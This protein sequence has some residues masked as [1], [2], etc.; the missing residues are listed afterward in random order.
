MK[1]LTNVQ[2]S[3]A[4]VWAS[5]WMHFPLF[6]SENMTMIF[7]LQVHQVCWYRLVQ[8]VF[9]FKISRSKWHFRF[10]IFSSKFLHC[11]KENP[12][13]QEEDN[14]NVL[15]AISFCFETELIVFFP[16]CAVLSKII[17][18]DIMCF[19]KEKWNSIKNKK[20]IV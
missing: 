10:S 18:S 1:H 11:Y 20:E 6:R 2:L 19:H 4:T 13:S 12:L 16:T 17:F 3:V 9:K 8:D 14:P 5:N 15:S 7:P